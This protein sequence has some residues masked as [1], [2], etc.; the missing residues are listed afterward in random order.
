MATTV[1]GLYDDR[2]AARTT[3]RALNEKGF[4]EEW[5]HIET[6][7]TGTSTFA[8]DGD[9]IS[10]LT[11][12]GVPRDE[13]EFYAEGVRRGGS[14]LILQ[15]PDGRAREAAEMMNLREPVMR[16]ERETDWR[17][18]G[19][20]G[21]DA[22]TEPYTAEEAEAERTRY[23]TARDE[24][25][26]HLTEAKEELHVGKREVE[27]G[28]VR[29]HKRVEE[30]PVEET[31][32]LH[33]EEVDVER[34]PGARATT[35]DDALF[36]EKTIE[37]RE[38]RE[39]PV[40]EKETKVTGEVVARKEAH[41]RSATIRDTV[42][43]TEVDVEQV[44]EREGFSEHRDVFREHCDTTYGK[45]EYATYEPAYQ[46]GYAYGTH[47]RFSD[48]EYDEMEPELQRTYEERH[49]QGTYHDARDAVRYGYTHAR[50]YA[51]A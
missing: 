43:E 20:D 39:E 29:L 13:A 6:H 37:M 45:G 30:H 46:F 36:E 15:T 18:R 8:R 5:I 16:E 17:T 26:E 14:L 32:H 50:S 25:E 48:Y 7:G 3:A 24:Q 41:E 44:G 19:Y 47:D 31:V 22:G 23:R 11:D 38:R 12:L 51:T 27:S 10:P 33:E 9:M 42:R 28:A 34:R 4:E 2:E 1:L 21:Y 35:N 49:G 40:V